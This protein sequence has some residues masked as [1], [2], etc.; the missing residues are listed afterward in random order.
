MLKRHGKNAQSKVNPVIIIA[1]AVVDSVISSVYKEIKKQHDEVLALYTAHHTSWV[2]PEEVRG[3]R[4]ARSLLADNTTE[5]VGTGIVFN[6][7]NVLFYIN[8][9]AKYEDKETNTT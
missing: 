1:F 9:T 5:T 8:S 6:H 7:T 3:N 4:R 2:I